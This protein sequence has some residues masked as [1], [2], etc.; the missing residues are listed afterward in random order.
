M[1]NFQKTL[2]QIIMHRHQNHLDFNYKV[3]FKK[4]VIRVS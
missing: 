3:V 1:D 4:N 2:L